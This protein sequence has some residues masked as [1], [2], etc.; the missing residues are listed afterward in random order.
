[1]KYD[2][3]SYPYKSNLKHCNFYIF[4][5]CKL[6]HTMNF[7]TVFK[8]FNIV[9][10]IEYAGCTLYNNRLIRMLKNAARNDFLRCYN[11]VYCQI[12]GELFA[13]N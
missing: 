11:C 13:L 1:M 9:F 7:I 12:D 3:Y 4:T 5:F 6:I 10:I 8:L 2:Y